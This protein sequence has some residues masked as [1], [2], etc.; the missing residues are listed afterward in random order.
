M[1]LRIL[2]LVLAIMVG[3]V[4][5]G[6]E[7]AGD[8]EAGSNDM[9]TIVDTTV[10]VGPGSTSCNIA[11]GLSVPPTSYLAD[12]IL[13]GGSP[14]P[15]P[16]GTAVWFCQTVPTSWGTTAPAPVGNE[17]SFMLTGTSTRQR[18]TLLTPMMVTL[19]P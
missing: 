9:G 12:T 10:V 14:M 6:C 3:L 16:P 1:K 19:D 15:I 11:S 8:G 7:K 4:A 5:I 17:V 13:V 2:M 18:G